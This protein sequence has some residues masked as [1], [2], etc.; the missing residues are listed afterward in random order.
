MRMPATGDIGKNIED[1][2][3]KI[4]GNL[5][6]ILER[7]LEGY[8]G[9]FDIE[10][11]EEE[12]PLKAICIFHIHNEK[13]VLTKKAKLWEADCNEY[14]Y[15]FSMPKLTKELY[16]QCEQMAYDKGME[17]IHPKPGHMYSYITAVF[18]CGES[19]AE[20]VRA[21]K[22]CRI[23]KNFRFSYYG[24]MDFH[25]LLVDVGSGRI[26]ANSSGREGKKRMEKMLSV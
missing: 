19:E 4:A 10:R 11:I 20:A 3:M 24:W 6:E 22:R 18:L 13:Y 15:L 1:G 17:Q 16:R 21:L 9:Y 5:E 7:L 25:T 23:H 8:Q 14:V 26:E 2:E 12:G